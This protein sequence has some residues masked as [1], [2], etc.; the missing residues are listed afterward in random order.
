MRWVAVLVM[1]A[2]F[3]TTASTAG[4]AKS[5]PNRIDPA[6]LAL[7]KA[8]PKQIFHVIVRAHSHKKDK[9]DR[10]ER[11]N[12]GSGNGQQGNVQKRED[13]EVGRAKKAIE[14]VAGQFGHSLSIV[15]GAS[16][17]LS[18][19]ALLELARDSSI[20]FI[21][22][23]HV[24]RAAFDPT[25]GAAAVTS[26]GIVA[27]GAPT[28]WTQYGVTGKGIGVAVI[29][30]GVA[31]HADLTG[32]IVASVDFTGG[33]PGAPLVAPADPGGHGT[34]VAGLIA[35]DGSAS[36]GAYTGVAPGAS[37]IDV[38]VIGSTGSTNVSTVLRGMQW[39]VA[40]RATYNIR[41]ANMS[42]GATPTTSYKN[43]PLATGVEVLT[44]SGVTVVAAA[45]NSGPGGTT[46]AT[47]GYDPFVI[48][49]GA[50][51]DSGTTTLA[52]DTLATWSSRGATKF[53]GLMKPDL[54]A[55]G[56]K[57]VSLRSPGSTLDQLFT[58]RQVAGLDSASPAYFRMSGTSMATPVVAGIVALML[59]RNPTLRP[60]QVKRRV[61]A[62]AT[63]LAFGS[64]TTTGV[65][66]VN[67]L[68]AVGSADSGLEYGA[69]RVTDGFATQM[70]AFLKGQAIT[71]RDQNHNGGVDS[72]GIRWK[73][74]TWNTI[75]WNE[76]TWEAL[77]WE[78]FNWA[79]IT[80]EGVTWA[81]ITWET[82]SL[83][84]D[85]LGGS[86]GWTLVN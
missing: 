59:E 46:I 33:A 63:P 53:D 51:D 22:A 80:W 32:R 69:S 17:T 45:G 28:V 36:G 47:P 3:V 48:T 43:D 6:L 72:N 31:P 9:N 14:H 2:L 86:G 1:A 49:V 25:Q 12:R 62:T 60:G 37:I 84:V 39:V 40:N 29:D 75:A 66:M 70:Y 38:R 65:G 67:A 8:N 73:D 82:T 18:G 19:A 26:P 58:E 83:S 79:G 4:E 74:I 50:I 57:M 21:S 11:D 30:S 52:D 64:V 27:T 54:V 85:I 78:A 76:I 35:G 61:K 10:I 55:P 20:G 13:R 56:R 42:L 16:A 23:D 71:W 24:I 41:V 34:H 7:A 81:E 5:D 68:A 77:S 15:G 44:F